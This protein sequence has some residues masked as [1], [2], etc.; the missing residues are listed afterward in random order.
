MKELMDTL[1]K[2][3]AQYP[4]LTQYPSFFL[5]EEMPA[6]YKWDPSNPFCCKQ[7]RR[8]P[9]SKFIKDVWITP[10]MSR[11]DAIHDYLQETQ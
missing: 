10:Y 3:H 1:D 2:L 7:E 9:T 5:E 11:M 4:H 8:K 6:Q